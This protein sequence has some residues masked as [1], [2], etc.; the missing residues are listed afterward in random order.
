MLP[1]LIDPAG[2]EKTKKQTENLTE[3]SQKKSFNL[4]IE[5]NSLYKKYIFSKSKENP[6]HSFILRQIIPV[7]P[8]VPAISSWG[9]REGHR[10]RAFPCQDK[11]P[12]GRTPAARGS[13]F[14][15]ARRGSAASRHKVPLRLP[16]ARGTSLLRPCHT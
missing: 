10:A 4:Y 3:F 6:C 12:G 8:P 7:V 2:K 15:P 14:H 1:L 11:N 16:R 13:C 9:L 5:H